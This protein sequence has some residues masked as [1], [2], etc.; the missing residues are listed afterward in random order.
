M[1]KMT[2]IL[3]A[4]AIFG[5]V[6]VG[7]PNATFA[8]TP[9]LAIASDAQASV[10]QLSAWPRIRDALLGRDRDYRRHTPPPP[11]PGWRDHGRGWGPRGPRIA[12]PPPPHPHHRPGHHFRHASFTPDGIMSDSLTI[13]QLPTV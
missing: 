12:P 6:L 1:T 8:A 4:A 10:V 2:K 7:T 11:P 3:A 5:T 13:E 9:T